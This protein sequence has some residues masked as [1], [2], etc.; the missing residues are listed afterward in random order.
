MYLDL[1]EQKGNK[2]EKIVLVKGWNKMF[3]CFRPSDN[4]LGCMEEFHFS[5]IFCP[6]LVLNDNPSWSCCYYCIS[7]LPRS[8]LLC[9]PFLLKKHLTSSIING[10][11]PIVTRKW[12]RKKALTLTNFPIFSSSSFSSSA[13]IF[14]VAKENKFG[15]SWRFKRLRNFCWPINAVFLWKK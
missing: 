2:R 11:H 8:L 6:I 10:I 12:L 15:K 13:F 7:T 9:F 1:W 5:I 4:M 3:P 14:F